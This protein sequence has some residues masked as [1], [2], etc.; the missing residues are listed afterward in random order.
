MRSAWHSDRL[1]SPAVAVVLHHLLLLGFMEK[2]IALNV[3]A[4]AC[5]SG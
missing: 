5:C 3:F 4:V 2:T 1:S